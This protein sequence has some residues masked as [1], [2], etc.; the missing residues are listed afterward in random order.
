MVTGILMAATRVLARDGYAAMSTNRVAAEAGVS[1]G[2]LYRYFADKDEIVETLRI[3]AGEAITARLTDAM[4]DATALPAYD[5]T[6]AV[7]AAL[8]G[9]LREHAAIMR[10][11]VNEVPLGAHAN[12]LPEVE[13]RL[14]Q[15]TLMFALQRM[16][17]LDR[18]ELD[19]RVYLAMGV[20]LASCLRIALEA[21]PRL[22]PEHLLDLLAG[23]LSL[24]LEGG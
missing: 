24:G 2:S 9:A 15:F 20:T 16:P 23:M 4:A 8:V 21:P 13:Q 6:R 17:D 3:Q 22:D 12:T 5:G 11:L 10:A 1:I 7:L 18:A 19:A 14:A